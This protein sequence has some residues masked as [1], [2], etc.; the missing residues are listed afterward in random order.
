MNKTFLQRGRILAGVLLLGACAPKP[1]TVRVISGDG[2]YVGTNTRSQFPQRRDCPHSGP[3]R[4]LVQAGV[5]YY[6]WNYYQYV[7]IQFLNNGT[8]SGSVPG[9]QLTGTYDGTTIQGDVT[10]GQCWL[11][12]TLRR[13]SF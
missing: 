13:R 4:L 1:A 3:F 2:D 7:P 10:D 12:F 11:H 5:A 8:L 6:R 9:I